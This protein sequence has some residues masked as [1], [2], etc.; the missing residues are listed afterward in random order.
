MSRSRMAFTLIELLVCIAI[1]SILAS[2]LFPVLAQVRD[3][4]R[5]TVCISNIQQLGTASSMYIQ[6]YDETYALSLYVSGDTITRFGQI[7]SIYDLILPYIEKSRILQ[8]PADLKAFDYGKVVAQYGL[9]PQPDVT[10]ASYVPNPGLF[11]CGCTTQLVRKHDVRFLSNLPFPS[12]QP[13]FYEGFLSAWL[14]TPAEGRHLGGMNVALADGHTHFMKLK[15]NSAPVGFDPV[16]GKFVDQWII[17]KGPFRLPPDSISSNRR[18][19][20]LFGI[21]IDANCVG[22]VSAP[23]TTNPSCE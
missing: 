7:Y 21:V 5:N 12:D 13:A 2:L 20:M 18:I 4:A 1:I 14:D 22:K 9:T 11:T 16:S 10:Y 15:K 17:E 3:F 19:W 6:D 8:C 23:C